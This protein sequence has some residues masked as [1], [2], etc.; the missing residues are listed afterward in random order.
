MNEE[1]NDDWKEASDEI[2]NF[3]KKAVS[4]PLENYISQKL[5]VIESQVRSVSDINSKAIEIFQL[6]QGQTNPQIEE[7]ECQLKSVQA[8][9]R[10]QGEGQQL[11]MR[12]QIINEIMQSRESHSEM[13]CKLAAERLNEHQACME[14]IGALRQEALQERDI[15]AAALARADAARVAEH[16]TLIQDSTSA[17]HATRDLFSSVCKSMSDQISA[18]LEGSF[19][20]YKKR[21]LF[22]TVLVSIGIALNM[23]IVMILLHHLNRLGL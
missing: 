21:I 17:H 9:M 2:R 4:E 19:R 20:A 13:L 12:G 11:T 16:Q 6:L 15:L 3:F 22:A 1:Q 7:V 14:H 5:K 10:V 8:Q 18:E 23:V